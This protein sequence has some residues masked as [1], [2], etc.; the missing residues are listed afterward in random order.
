MPEAG[1]SALQEIL[2]SAPLA[3]LSL[4]WKDNCNVVWG[5]TAANLPRCPPVAQIILGKKWQR[6]KI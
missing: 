4:G 3:Y 2:Q 6:R 5:L 1:S